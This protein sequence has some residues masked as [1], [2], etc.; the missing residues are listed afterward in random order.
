MDPEPK[1]SSWRER[2][3]HADQEFPLTYI[4]AQP[5]RASAAGA[6]EGTSHLDEFRA[7]AESI[8]EHEAQ[9]G[10]LVILADPDDVPAARMIAA[11]S[12]ARL[13]AERGQRV[14][15]AQTHVA[16]QAFLPENEFEEVEG[17]VDLVLYGVSPSITCRPTRLPRIDVLSL[18]SF[19]PEPGSVY[20]ED[21][22]RRAFGQLRASYDVV[23]MMVNAR[24]SSGGYNAL[25]G[26]GDAVV[27]VTNVQR[28]EELEDLRQHLKDVDMPVWGAVVFTSTTE[29]VDLTVEGALE[30]RRR[31]RPVVIDAAPP[32]VIHEQRSS[33][34]FRRFALAIAVVLLGFAGWWA[35]MQFLR[36]ENHPKVVTH[37]PVVADA[38]SVTPSQQ[39]PDATSSAEEPPSAADEAA[40]PTG[41]AAPAAESATPTP[42]AGAAQTDHPTSTTEQPVET[43][44]HASDV[45]SP[46]GTVDEPFDA[47][48]ATPPAAQAPPPADPAAERRARLE[49]LLKRAPGGGYGLYVW[50]FPDSLE[51]EGAL[52][53]LL[54]D[55]FRPTVV[56]ANIAGRGRW[57]RVVVGNF[58]RRQDAM[59]ARDFLTR[60]SDVDWAGPVLVK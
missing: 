52:K 2:L 10:V 46:A 32:L 56:G 25:I 53:P 58:P 31:S 22:L 29:T 30:E 35:W 19:R 59:D 21:E 57:Y 11:V 6:W 41:D 45:G 51:A 40:A 1:D 55:G 37:V 24:V 9:E 28:P 38:G 16:E 20:P 44:D 7:L 26:Q 18:G 54:K 50:S 42:T 39:T 13:L 60:R 17:F 27:L 5:D 47:A 36:G 12:L 8:L 33:P 14:L 15:I 3:F 48:A 49:T 34:F 4:G 43:A 23:L